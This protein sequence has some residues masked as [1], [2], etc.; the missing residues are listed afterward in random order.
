MLLGDVDKCQPLYVS[1][2]SCLSAYLL[3]N[4]EYDDHT[5]VYAQHT[6]LQLTFIHFVYDV[7]VQHHAQFTSLSEACGAAGVKE[8]SALGT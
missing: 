3:P 7:V 2:Q 5:A 1:M 8:D 6:V 4:N